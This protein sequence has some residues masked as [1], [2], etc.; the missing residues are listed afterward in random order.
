[1][2]RFGDP[3]R[4]LVVEQGPNWYCVTLTFSREASSYLPGSNM[5]PVAESEKFMG[6]TTRCL[7]GCSIIQAH[8]QSK[9]SPARVRSAFLME[10]FKHRVDPAHA[11][12]S[13]LVSVRC[14]TKALTRYSKIAR[15][16]ATRERRRRRMFQESDADVQ[17]R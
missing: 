6:G 4:V 14:R 17:S 5:G 7:P 1:M 16:S 13:R 12:L 15:L 9:H 11:T 2:F 3:G 8:L 10:E